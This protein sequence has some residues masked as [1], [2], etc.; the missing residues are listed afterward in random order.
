MIVLDTNVISELVRAVPAPRVWEWA[1]TV[2]PDTLTT[3]TV[4]EAELRFGIAIMP[5]GRR[6]DALAALI[7]ELFARRLAGR[8]LPLDRGAVVHYAAFMAARRRS[9]RPTKPLDALIA[10]TALAHGATAIATRN[11]ADF[12]GCGLELI[13]H[14]APARP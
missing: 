10:A 7:D 11:T 13:D 4:T 12:E 9:G 14:W 2:A 3:T 1:A 6:R 5:D 8:I